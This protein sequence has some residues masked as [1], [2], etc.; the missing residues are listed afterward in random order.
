MFDLQS[1]LRPNVR[2]LKPYRCARDDYSSGVLLDANENSYGPPFNSDVPEL[3][4]YPDPHQLELRTRIADFRSVSADHVFVGV[5]SDEAIDLLMRVLGVPG[6]D[7][8]MITPPTYGMYKVSANINDLEVVSVPLT[9]EFELRV[10]AMLEAVTPEVKLIFVCSPGNPTSK[11]CSR[12]SIVE[13][14]KAYTTGLVVVDEAYIDYALNDTSACELIAEY[15]NLVVLQTLS[16]SFGLAG[17]RLGMLFGNADLVDT[18]MKVKAPYNV[19]KLTSKVAI[20][21]MKNSPQMKSHVA[22]THEQRELVELGLRNLKSVR[23][24]YPSDANFLLVKI[25]N[26]FQVYKQMAAQGVVIRYRGDQMYC[27]DCVRITI[28]T[29]EEN[30]QMLAVLA[31]IEA[32]LAE[33]N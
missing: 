15:P 3:N 18:L 31:K 1:L 21:G 4:R 24:I 12:E 8:I 16:K 28:G 29:A 32:S 30:V 22:S 26:S 10:D 14:L 9:P 17:I 25:D 7:K 33:K 13:L 27:E 5:G 19:N 11:C 2:N 6:K 20:E 23:K